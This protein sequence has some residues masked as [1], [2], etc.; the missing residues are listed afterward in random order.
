MT[1]YTAA[2]L[3]ELVQRDGALVNGRIYT[4]P[5]IFGLEMERIFSK[6]WVYVGHESQ[7][8]NP[9]DYMTGYLVQQPII[10]TRDRAGQIHVLFNR[11]T[12]RG[13]K[14][15][16]RE[17]GNERLLTCMYHGW[18]FGHDGELRGIPLKKDFPAEAVEPCKASLARPPRVDAYRGFIFASL[19]PD[20][21]PLRDYLGAAASGIDEIVDRAPAGT[22][23]LSAGCHRYIYEGNWKLQTDNLG[24]MYHPVACHSST[25][26]EDGKQF[27]RRPGD[28]GGRAAFLGADGEPIVI[29]TGV[30]GFLRGHSSEASLFGANDIVK[31]ETRQRGGIIDEYR[32]LLIE[33]HGVEKTDEILKN[34]RHSMTLF[35]NLDVLMVQT[36]VR[37]VIPLAYNRTEVRIYPVH[38]DGAPDELNRQI[39]KFLNITHSAASFIQTDDL[40]AFKR[41][42]EGLAARSPQWLIV[43]RGQ[44]SEIDEG[45]GAYFGPRASE[46]GQ[47]MR[48]QYWR[49]LMMA[50]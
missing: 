13:A 8:A 19:N 17:R 24:D 32:S 49:E 31:E 7:V 44:G 10:L 47:R 26:D 20:V 39:I 25:V 16:N 23:R 38:L 3:G 15:V 21:E 48:H 29:Q 27:K 11:C 30:R 43:A 18:A 1:S 12:H 42:Q 33:Q 46:V 41:Q 9:G 35:P 14:I 37:V 4:D 2:G 6:V 50:E 45:N 36:S 40:E 5:E 22:I 34:R 28:E